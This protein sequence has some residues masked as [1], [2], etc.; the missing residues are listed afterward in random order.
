M[1]KLIARICFRIAVFFRTLGKQFTKQSPEREQMLEDWRQINKQ[2]DLRLDYNLN[3]DSIVFDMG[4]Y[5][6]DWSSEIYARYR[7]KIEI[8]EPYLP[9]AE[10]IK[11]RFRSNPDIKVRTFGL[12]RKNEQML[13][14]DEADSTSVFKTKG[15]TAKTVQI[16][17]REAKAFLKSENYP[18]IDLMKINIEGGEYNLLEH[19]IEEKLVQNIENIQVQ[20]HHFVPNARTRMEAIQKE[21]SKTH[22]MTYHYDFFWENWERK[23]ETGDGSRFTAVPD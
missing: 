14:S 8:F 20:F 22:K 6:G 7:S 1:K 19:L 18:H 4:G 23:G 10:Q 21:L 13:M 16:E 17:L 15:N 9:F 5:K 11:K 2:R 12:D 3:A